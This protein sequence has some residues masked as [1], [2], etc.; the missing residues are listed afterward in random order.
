MTK[1]EEV[2]ELINE[3]Q[4]EDMCAVAYSYG[5]WDGEF[6]YFDDGSVLYWEPGEFAV[7]MITD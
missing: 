7:E 5:E 2:A 4:T 3:A 1:A 6:A